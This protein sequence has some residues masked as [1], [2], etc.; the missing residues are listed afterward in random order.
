MR[1]SIPMLRFLTIAIALTIVG[2]DAYAQRLS[3]DFEVQL[4]TGVGFTPQTVPLENT[5]TSAV[6]VCTYNLPSPASPSAIPRIDNITSTSFDLSI[7]SLPNTNAGTGSVHCIIAEEGLHTLPDG[8]QVQ[9]I[10]QTVTDVLGLS[11]GNFEETVDIGPLVN[12]GFANPIALGAVISSNDARATA[13]HANDCENRGNEPFLSGVGDGICV[14]YHIGQQVDVAP[15]NQSYAAETVGVIITDEGAGTVGAFDYVIARGPNTIDG[16]GN[17]GAAYAVSGDFEIGVATQAAENGGQG[18]WAVLLGAD[19]LPNNQL[20]LGIEEE[21]VAGD[22]SRSHI[23][24]IVDYWLFSFAPAPTLAASKSVEVFDPLNEGLF[25]IPGND[26]LYTI[27]LT[28]NGAGLVDGNTLFFVDALPAE[29]AFFNG[30]ADGPG[31]A[32]GAVIFADSGSGLTFDPNSDVA[33][34]TTAPTD[35]SDCTHS[36]AAGFDPAI[37]YVCFNPQ[38]Q[39]QAGSPSPSF[40]LT[41]RARLQ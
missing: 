37:R 28:N 33:F 15:P 12:T 36:P 14:G 26:V 21:I 2:G 40:S 39:M 10:T 13:F 23:T 24:E 30:D 32:L 4:I 6:P 5:Y 34:A 17:N 38:G 35:F 25:A 7:Q 3:D 11:A 9:A 22:S 41:F 8:R 16:V 18:G 19:P 20:L 31:P 27:T 1:N 29:V